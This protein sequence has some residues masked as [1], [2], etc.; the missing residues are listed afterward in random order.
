MA[1]K[2]TENR[3]GTQK[4]SRDIEARSGGN[5]LFM[6]WKMIK[7][8]GGNSRRLKKKRVKSHLPGEGSIAL[9]AGG[10][11]LRYT[12]KSHDKTKAKHERLKTIRG[13]STANTTP[14]I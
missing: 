3:S 5:I 11:G 8:L 14:G 9:K 4:R 12:K 2:K 13:R 6:I 7:F 10:R 1:G